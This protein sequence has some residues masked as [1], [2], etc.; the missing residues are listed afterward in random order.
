M[1]LNQYGD[2]DAGVA[3][4]SKHTFTLATSGK[5]WCTSSL[6]AFDSPDG[7]RQLTI[8]AQDI[9]CETACFKVF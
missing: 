6:Q 9:N 3:S 4:A 8:S 7:E 2:T 5:T 1:L